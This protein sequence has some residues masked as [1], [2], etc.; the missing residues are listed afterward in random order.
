MKTT[1]ILGVEITNPKQEL[2]IMRGIPGSGK[3]TLAKSIVGNGVIHSTDNVIESISDYREFF[4]KMIESKDFSALHKAHETNYKNAVNS[5][6]Q[7]I[8]PVI[9]DNTHIKANEAK[10]IVVKA[11]ELGLDED[12]I[13]IHDIGINGLDAKI[14]ASRNT[15]G[16]PL[17]KIEAMIQS[18]N[19]VGSLTISKI[20]E[21]KDIFK[22]SDILYSAVVLDNASITK[23][24]QVV[25]VYPAEFPDGW[26]MGRNGGYF[27][28]HMTICLG[29]L[30]DKT[31]L[32]KEVA[33]TV[34]H[35]GKSDMAIA[36][37]VKGYPSKNEIPHITLAINPEG[38][39]PKMSNDITKWQDLK[40]FT[41]IGVVSEVSKYTK[42]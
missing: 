36:F 25:G 40:H 31:D 6:K 20:I 16:V 30:K 17:E 2:F 5:L 41:V 15:H 27:C 1:N 24:L 34:T 39:E 12:N 37:K 11:L 21:S 23:L 35:V 3:S 8:T 4:A 18:Y 7:G 26:I 22:A 33:I 9:I 19:S 14:L 32:G 29:P 10:K 13:K 42:K 28:D 38:G